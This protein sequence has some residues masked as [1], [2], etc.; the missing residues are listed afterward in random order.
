MSLVLIRDTW[1]WGL[2]TTQLCNK[3]ALVVSAIRSRQLQT[4]ESLF[5]DRNADQI[6]RSSYD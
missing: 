4:A 6:A 2:E 3:E 1:S 5:L